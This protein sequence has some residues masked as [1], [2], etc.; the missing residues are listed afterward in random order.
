MKENYKNLIL[1]QA[2][3]I[4]AFNRSTNRL[5]FFANKKDEAQC[6]IEAHNRERMMIAISS[7]NTKIDDSVKQTS[8]SVQDK[9]F[10]LAWGKKISSWLEKTYN[11][12]VQIVAALDAEQINTQKELSNTFEI[13]QKF[14]G[15]NLNNVRK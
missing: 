9:E 4:D 10:I 2:K 6:D 8:L 7:F 15:Y 1:R 11:S 13:N 14:K 12:D 3:L 5:L